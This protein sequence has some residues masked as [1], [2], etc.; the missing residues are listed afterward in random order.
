MFAILRSVYQRPLFT[1]IL[2][3]VLIAA[4]AYG[5]LVHKYKFFPYQLIASINQ[6]VNPSPYGTSTHKQRRTQLFETVGGKTDIVFIGDSHTELGL[7]NEVFPDTSV[8][9]RGINEDTTADVLSRLDS[10]IRLKPRQAFLMLGVNDVLTGME[11]EETMKNYRN[12]VYSLK[13]SNI[14]IVIQSTVQ[15]HLSLCGHEN[16][17]SVNALNDALMQLSV[18]EDLH[19]LYL[20]SLSDSTG[21]ATPLTYDGIHLT[22]EG[23]QIWIN[24]LNQFLAN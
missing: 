22:P 14:D 8:A 18:K 4:F 12:I 7:W 24:T 9:N 10:I 20:E 13:Q 6:L 3:A 11:I 21:L 5:L 19:Y 23:Y 1:C 15:C 16:I 17:E 2:L